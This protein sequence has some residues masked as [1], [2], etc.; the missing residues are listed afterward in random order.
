[1]AAVP[2]RPL[3]S[4]GSE[5]MKLLLTTATLALG[6]AMPAVAQDT[7]RR[8]PGLES[9]LAAGAGQ[10]GKQAQA[11]DCS[12]MWKRAD[13]SSKGVL[14]GKDLDKLRSVLNTVDTNHDNKVTQTEFVTA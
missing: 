1:M 14:E 4:N 11:Q 9:P 7:P 8:D 6:L 2:I 10:A 13:A 12:A 3:H 5:V